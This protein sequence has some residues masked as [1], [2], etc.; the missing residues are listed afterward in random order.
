MR[1]CITTNGTFG[2]GRPFS[3][4][5]RPVT[6]AGRLERDRDRV[7]LVALDHEQGA[8]R[9]V[10]VDDQDRL[11]FPGSVC[12]NVNSAAAPGPADWVAHQVSEQAS[13]HDRLTVRTD[14]F[15]V[16][17]ASLHHDD[18]GNGDLLGIGGI[19]RHQGLVLLR[20][21]REG[22]GQNV[23]GV[24]GREWL[25]G[26]KVS[27]DRSHR[28]DAATRKRDS[29][30][31]AVGVGAELGFVGPVVIAEGRVGTFLEMRVVAHRVVLNDRLDR[32]SIRAIRHPSLDPDPALERDI[33]AD[34]P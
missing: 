1:S 8:G 13:L 29:A 20:L 28:E 30:K 24:L 2:R 34:W 25:G 10:L 17:S 4:T 9:L 21:V 3:S 22:S 27:F 32:S 6:V 11:V 23:A 19:D 18:V 14:D 16:L 15:D 5:S 31:S 33:D 26:E 7:G 12:T